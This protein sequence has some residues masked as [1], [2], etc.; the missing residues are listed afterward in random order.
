MNPERPETDRPTDPNPWIDPEP[1]I[2]N[3][4][5]TVLAGVAALALV[6][7]LG[8]GVYLATMGIKKTA[9]PQPSPSGA[10]ETKPEAYHLVAYVGPTAAVFVHNLESGSKTEVIPA[11]PADAP[12]RTAHGG[13]RRWVSLSRNGNI[14]VA[15]GVN[16]NEKSGVGYVDLT[17]RDQPVRFLTEGQRP[18]VS[19]DGR[20]VA[21][22]RA[23]AGGRGVALVPLSGG[24]E[25][26]VPADRGP[27][28]SRQDFLAEDWI[29]SNRLILSGG[30]E[31]GVFHIADRSG[32][33]PRMVTVPQLAA[34]GSKIF[35]LLASPDGQRVL[36]EH[37]FG[38]GYDVGVAAING[39][40]FRKVTPDGEAPWPGSGYRLGAWAPGGER[41]AFMDF[42]SPLSTG[43]SSGSR[44]II[45]S[46][47]RITDLEGRERRVIDHE[48]AY[49]TPMC[50]IHSRDG[51][52]LA[53]WLFL[54]DSQ[55]LRDSGELALVDYRDG[56]KKALSDG[57]HPSA[58]GALSCGTR[59]PAP[60]R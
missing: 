11:P 32:A 37:A 57:G 45:L 18:V 60:G 29:D 58:A 51:E 4:A 3:R 15:D 36:V 21:V 35:D 43:P 53:A 9:S 44:D 12:C 38:K 23:E 20:T 19:P 56:S 48:L 27:G 34:R 42:Y 33:V 2:N 13:C 41:V 7:T 52:R 1:V 59:S 47:I 17:S 39:S 25:I 16:E 46:K 40:G 22:H 10:Q 49:G 55:G 31:P 8:A 30:V 28:G 6:T 14:L 5:K 24:K 54:R 26:P 50:W